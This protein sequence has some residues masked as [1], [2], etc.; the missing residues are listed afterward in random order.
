[1]SAEILV[2]KLPAPVAENPPRFSEAV[3]TENAEKYSERI[4]AEVLYRIFCEENEPL[5]S[6]VMEYFLLEC[7]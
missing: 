6:I 4:S 5:Q 7:D 3:P 1:M 2:F